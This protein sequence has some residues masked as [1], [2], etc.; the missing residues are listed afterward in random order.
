MHIGIAGA[1]LMGRLLAWQL[2][3]AGQQVTL[4]DRD[5]IDGEASAAKVAAAMLAPF[6]EVVNCE[7]QVFNWGLEGLELWPQLLEQLISDGANAVDYQQQGSIVVAHPQDQAYLDHFNQLLQSRAPQYADDIH[8]LTQTDISQLE[9]ALAQRFNHGTFL[10]REGCIDNWGLLAEL[11]TTIDRLGGHWHSGVEINSVHPNTIISNNTSHRFDLAI[12]TR[13]LGSKPQLSDLRGVRGEV[14]WVNAPEVQLSR[15]VRLMHPRYQLYI[16]PKP[17][18]LFVI[19]ATEIESESMKPIT[20]RSSLELQSA[21]YSVDSGFAEANIIKAYANCRPAFIDNLPR[22]DCQQG[23]MRV[24]GLYR[25]GYLLSPTVLMAALNHIMDG[26]HH[27]IIRF[28][29]SA[30]TMN[31][32]TSTISSTIKASVL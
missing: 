22:I 14:L 3:R 31:T 16:A 11:A 20:V 9:P 2:L 25:H 17:N 5:N 12:D 26:H 4:F 32:T 1:G 23:L 28:T 19:G 13:G 8:L 21:L 6:S 24:N 27:D 7:P 15:P 18:N 10:R 29:N 30:P